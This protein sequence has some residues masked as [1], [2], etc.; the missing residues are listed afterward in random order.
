M[1]A[2]AELIS[3]E[4]IVCGTDWLP[5]Y[6]IRDVNKNPIDLSNINV[7]LVFALRKQGA[8]SPAVTRTL[9]AGD[10]VDLPNGGDDG[11]FRAIFDG[12]ATA[13]LAPGYYD[14][15]VVFTDESK[16]PKTIRLQARGGVQFTRSRTGV[17]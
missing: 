5:K 12:P 10:E 3:V 1:T 7:D 13:A 4:E 8:A 16:T 14:V 6:L 17:I 9:T 2:P 11:I 15:E